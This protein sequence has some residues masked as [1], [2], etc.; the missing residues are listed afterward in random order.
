MIIRGKNVSK[1]T[2][3][4]TNKVKKVFMK[5]S[6]KDDIINDIPYLRCKDHR[7][8]K[9]F[10]DSM[11]EQKYG[12]VAGNYHVEHILPKEIKIIAYSFSPASLHFEFPQYLIHFVFI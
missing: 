6:F 12:Y 8:S 10:A 3:R 2:I 7:S 1:E 5:R 9:S 4:N 11:I